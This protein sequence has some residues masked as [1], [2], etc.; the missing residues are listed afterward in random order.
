MLLPLSA[1]PF[2]HW[3]NDPEGV[4]FNSALDLVQQPPGG[5]DAHSLETD[6]IAMA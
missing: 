5:H 2:G 1:R 6:D 4:R 3:L